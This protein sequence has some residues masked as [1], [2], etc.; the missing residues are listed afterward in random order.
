MNF[1]LSPSSFSQFVAQHVF[2][3][4]EYFDNI[5]L[6]YLDNRDFLINYLKNIGLKEFV[7]PKGAF[8]LYINISKLH[9]NSY[10]FC[11]RMVEDIG[12]TIAPGIDFDNDKGISYIRISYACKKS[13]LVEALN[14]IR[15]WI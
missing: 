12:V 6:E 3:Y 9:N 14:L 15:K 7:L 11:K 10:E 13:E 8:Y 5:V 2:N 4:Y 1:Y